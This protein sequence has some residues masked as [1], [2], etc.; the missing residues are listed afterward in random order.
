MV[1]DFG[2]PVD[3]SMPLTA[4]DA[5]ERCSDDAKL[6]QPVSY[7]QRPPTRHGGHGHHRDESAA[8]CHLAHLRQP[9]V[10]SILG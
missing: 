9:G 2:R 10:D 1:D 3:A 7:L 6:S 4:T 8:Y 5:V